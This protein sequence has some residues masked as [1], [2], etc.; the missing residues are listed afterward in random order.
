[1]TYFDE[2]QVKTVAV[3]FKETQLLNDIIQ[4][5]HRLKIKLLI[6]KCFTSI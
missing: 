4:L 2:L 5:T 6:S 1:M 3:S